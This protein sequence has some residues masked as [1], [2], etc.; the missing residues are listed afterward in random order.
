[1]PLSCFCQSDSHRSVPHQMLTVMTII[2]TYCLNQ[3]ANCSSSSIEEHLF[4]SGTLQPNGSS[5]SILEKYRY[6]TIA[7]LRLLRY[8]KAEFSCVKISIR[9]LS[10]YRSSVSDRASAERCASR[11]DFM[12]NET[13]TLSL[14][15]RERTSLGTRCEKEMILLQRMRQG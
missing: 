4:P 5:K 2:R 1:M 7:C 9:M 14:L 15:E 10:Q 12:C 3:I 11:G 13:I 8:P 6:K